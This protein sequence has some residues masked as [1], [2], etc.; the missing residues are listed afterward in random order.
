MRYIWV[1][2]VACRLVVV[3]TERPLGCLE[4]EAV[5]AAPAITSAPHLPLEDRPNPC[6]IHGKTLKTHEKAMFQKENGPVGHHSQLPVARSGR[7]YKP[8]GL[9]ELNACGREASIKTS[10]RT[11]NLSFH[12]PNCASMSFF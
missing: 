7:E 9:K 4:L 11:L 6:K 5:A 3:V 8:H 10:T 2:S 12:Q 1:E